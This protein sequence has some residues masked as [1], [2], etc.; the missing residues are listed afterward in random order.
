M[1]DEAAPAPRVRAVALYLPQFHPTPEN[2]EWWGPGFTEWTNVAR[3]RRLFPGHRQPLVPG[4]LGFTD[5]RVP[6]TR[7]AQAELARA[8]G[9]EAFC[10]WHYWFGGRRILE[11]PFDEVVASGEPDFP[12]CVGW[13]NES[14]TGVWHGSR[15]R[16]LIEQTYP[17]PDDDRAH[18]ESLLPALHDRRY[19]R[20]DGNPLLFVYRPESL[21]DAAAFADRWRELAVAGGLPGLHLVGQTRG[22]WLPST[23][24]FD[25]AVTVAMPAREQRRAVEGRPLDWWLTVA[26]AKAP[27][28][29][30]IYS[31]RHWAPFFP[32]LLDDDE[33]YPVVVPNWDNTP[34]SGRGGYVFSGST[35]ELFGQ[36]AERAVSLIADRPRERRLVFVKSWNEWAE[37]NHLEPDTRWG[38]GYLEALREAVAG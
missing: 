36:Q 15:D 6:E 34:R 18:V 11:R 22:R 2:D 23:H 33:S 31:Y 14:W 26:S 20:V 28:L 19:L 9:I 25:A 8:H 27:W 12:F 24:G 30:S 5:L 16:V 29:P 13:A 38:R 32:W 1:S 17:G 10:Y 7:A 21:P 35:P 4:E 37:G 3:A